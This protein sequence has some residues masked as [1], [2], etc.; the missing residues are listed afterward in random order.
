MRWKEQLL[1]LTPYQ[2]GKSIE[3]VKKQFQLEQII[4]LASNE[5]PFGC[6]NMVL[7]ALQSNLLNMPIYPDGYASSMR[8]ELAAFLQVEPEKLIFGNGSDNLI[9]II[10][11]ALLHPG[12]STVMATP[13][14]SQYRHNAVIEGAVIKEV[15]LL[16]GEHD[17]H[18]MLD[19]MDEKTNVV[20]LCSPNNPTG[21]YIPE[22][23]LLA[24]LEKVPS[25]CLVVLDE[26]YYEY[27][28]ADDYYDAISLTSKYPNLIVLRTFSKIYGLASLRVGYGVANPAIIKA[29]EPGREPFNV[30][31]FGQAAALA[32]I[33]D[34]EFVEEC[35][36]KNR[37]GLQQ[38]YDFCHQ[39][40]L[41]YFPSQTNFILIDFKIDGDTVFQYLLERGYIVRSGKALGFPTSVRITVGTT[42]QNEGLLRILDE[43][44][45]NQ[46]EEQLFK[47]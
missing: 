47:K 40:G 27:V 2:P 37:T 18:G 42:E 21:T 29:L 34:Q 10:S 23:A 3:S 43:F 1:T 41:E 13:T 17:L 38:Y 35:K 25:S 31:S 24:F 44:L 9:Q 22:T 5:N 12:A 26:A 36:K 33:E 30:N 16:N 46:R 11:R 7:S 39:H 28:V 19:A 45:V 6:S 15:P 14:F 8:D 32:A 4:K 20:W